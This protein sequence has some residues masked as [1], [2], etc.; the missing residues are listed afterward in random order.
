MTFATDRPARRVGALTV[1]GVITGLGEAIVVILVVAIA[2]DRLRGDLPL[3]GSLPDGTWARAALALAVVVVLAASHLGSA[4]VTAR[5]AAESQQT[6][7]GLLLDAYLRAGAQAQA[8]ERTGQLQELVM[9]GATQ[10]ALGTQQAARALTM[11]FNLVVVVSAA[12]LVSVWATL[13]LVAVAVLSV[14]VVRPFRARTRRMA[15][16]S[17]EAS[18]VLATDVTEAATLA[19]ELRVA[20]VVGAARARL[21]ERVLAARRLFESVHLSAGAVPALMRDVTIAVVIV[22]V[23]TVAS[24][25]EVSLPALGASVLLLLRALSFAQGLSGISAQMQERAANVE[26][27]RGFLDRWDASAR[28]DGTRRCARVRRVALRSVSYTYPGGASAALSDVSLALEPGEQIGLVGRT[29]AG[30]STLAL[31]ALGLIVPDAGEVLVDDAPLTE[32][33]GADWQRRIAWVPQEPRLLT[34]TARENIHFLREGVRDEAVRV[35]AEAAG[36]GPELAA[37]PDGLD[38]HVGPGGAALSLGQRQRIVLA[39]A[40]AGEPDL[41]VLDEPTSAL[42]VHTEVAVRDA[43]AELRGRTTVVTIAHRLSTLD[44]CDRV[45]V[46][47]GGRLVALGAPADLAARDSFY[48]EALTLSGLRP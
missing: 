16:E 35:A 17:A 18:S 24:S 12:V 2:S 47:D 42:D 37:W 40:L 41:L 43:I 31:V 29:G 26:R 33:R 38:H 48:R 46:V 19:P 8:R 30:K 20:G 27:I 34:G 45:A 32:L 9:T 4:W 5:T 23:A 6:V 21:E 22:A 25:G 15:R 3:L 10:V 44:A 28:P 11:S 14:L 13:G 7:R 1:L 36:L 39:R